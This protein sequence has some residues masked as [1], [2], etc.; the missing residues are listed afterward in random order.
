MN[1][2]DPISIINKYLIDYH[3]SFGQNNHKKNNNLCAFVSSIVVFL[4]VKFY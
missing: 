4:T 1:K 2:N 3:Q